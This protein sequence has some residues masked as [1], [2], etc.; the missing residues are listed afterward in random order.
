MRLH[1][2]E[3]VPGEENH[4]R[5]ETDALL[6]STVEG[7]TQQVEERMDSQRSMGR[8]R[9]V[10]LSPW[11]SGVL[12]QAAAAGDRGSGKWREA[13]RRA[14]WVRSPEWD[15]GGYGRKGH[16]WLPGASGCWVTHE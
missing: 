14:D 2:A 11:K 9:S 8:T 5:R 10:P 15:G 7:D 6:K 1:H 12:V 3:I 16:S 4:S 13:Q